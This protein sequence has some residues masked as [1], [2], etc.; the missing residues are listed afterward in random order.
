MEDES[1]LRISSAL[2]DALR[3]VPSDGMKPPPELVVAASLHRLA[4]EKGLAQRSDPNH[5][6]VLSAGLPAA[7]LKLLGDCFDS[8]AGPASDDD[9]RNGLYETLITLSTMPAALRAMNKSRPLS[10]EALLTFAQIYW[11]LDAEGPRSKLPI[12]AKQMRQNGDMAYIKVD[13]ADEDYADLELAQRANRTPGYTKA[14]GAFYNRGARLAALVA[15]QLVDGHS[16]AIGGAALRSTQT[17]RGSEWTIVWR[18]ESAPTRK[19]AHTSV[20]VSQA[21]ATV[22]TL[23]QLRQT[24]TAE[25]E[26]G[27]AAILSTTLIAIL[28]E[29]SEKNPGDHESQL[30]D[31]YLQA[32]HTFVVAGRSD[33][34]LGHFTNAERTSQ[35]LADLRP[36]E[37]LH[38]L[39]LAAARTMLGVLLIPIGRVD[40]AEVVL[41]SAVALA[42]ALTDEDAR[43]EDMLAASLSMLGTLFVQTERPQDAQTALSRAVKISQK[44]VKQNPADS[45]NQLQLASILTTLGMLHLQI[46][47]GTRAET[48]IIRSIRILETLVSEGGERRMA[49]LL[50]ASDRFLLGSI[51]IY[52]DRYEAAAESLMGALSL[53]KVLIDQRSDGPT[54]LLLMSAQY[55]L[56]IAYG[57]LDQTDEAVRS[58]TDAVVASR[59]LLATAAAGDLDSG[60]Q[61]IRASELLSSALWFLGAIYVELERDKEAEVSLLEAVEVV[62]QSPHDSVD[63]VVLV[64]SLDLLVDLYQRQNRL[65][66]AERVFGLRA[67]ADDQNP[68][69]PAIA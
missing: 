24:S 60:I 33:E 55:M 56:G 61:S 54:R 25:G 48:L 51:Y 5:K 49:R 4:L 63:R 65:A 35:T 13:G 30:A 36:D 17:G 31:E 29:R 38:R 44:L 52:L 9:V 1:E 59:V 23:R 7:A 47:E 6:G 40:E 69:A 8:N 68:E 15:T 67:R 37:S 62:R 18:A 21:D 45:T 42:Q 41:T 66:D 50:L 43:Q 58:L 14:A 57:T 32:G 3:V 12:P 22:G 46:D 20:R 19:T 64:E 10:S 39:Q 28:R 26:L 34:A 16:A 2:L 53:V 11:N 27:Q